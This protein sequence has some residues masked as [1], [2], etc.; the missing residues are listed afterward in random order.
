MALIGISL[1]IVGIVIGLLSWHPWQDD[2]LDRTA[3]APV[4]VGQSPPAEESQTEA[5]DVDYP[6]A[7]I[8]GGPAG[9]IT[10]NS[11][12]FVWTGSDDKTPPSE[13][14]SS[15]KLEGYDADWSEYEIVTTASYADLPDG[16]YTFRVRV[17]DQAG[18]LDSSPDSWAFVIDVDDQFPDT[19]IGGGPAGDIAV[20]SAT[21]VWTG[22]DDK[23][24]APE[25]VSSYRLEGYD[26]AWSEYEVVTTRSYTDLPDGAYTFRV[27]VRDQAGKVDPSPASRAF[28][29]E[30]VPEV[31]A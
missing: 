18:K 2:S 3:P 31:G 10:V 16:A 4:A 22:G 8:T 28:V 15:Y 25:L 1:T 26:A 24:P 5:A 11:A 17:R 7:Q 27:R 30:T 29:V 14:L 13:L 20:N 12:T 21:F 9:D 23:T 19:Q 6:D